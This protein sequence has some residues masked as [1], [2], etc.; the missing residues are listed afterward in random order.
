VSAPRRWPQ[1]VRVDEQGLD[2]LPV[3]TL[4]T[5]SLNGIYVEAEK[6]PDGRWRLH[7]RDGVPSVALGRCRSSGEVQRVPSAQPPAAPRRAPAEHVAALQ[8]V[9]AASRRAPAAT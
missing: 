3:G 5:F 4:R 8:R 7:G 1:L 9:A 6:R 2:A